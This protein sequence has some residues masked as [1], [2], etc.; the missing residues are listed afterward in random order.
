[1]KISAQVNGVLN[2]YFDCNFILVFME[3][4]L[5]HRVDIFTLPEFD[6]LP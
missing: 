6:E 1:M 4:A 3:M 5:N 2:V